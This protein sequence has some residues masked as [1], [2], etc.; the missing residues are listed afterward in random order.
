MPLSENE[1]NQVAE[2]LLANYDAATPGLIF[3]EG[4]RLELADA[5][6]LQTA[7]TKLRE[8]R[9][10]K[11]IGYK[12]GAVDP[13]NQQM[14]GLPHPVWG[15]LWESELHE[16]GA[17]LAKADYANIAIE[18][19]FGITL[20]CDLSPEMSDQEIAS[21]V[22]AV[23][24]VLELH[25][26]VMRSERP[27]GQELIANNCINCGVVRGA[28]VTDLI[29]PRETD[30]KLIYDGETVDEWE[31]LRWPGDI[32]SAMQ[33]LVQS[34]DESGLGLK[35]GDLVLTSAWGPPIPVNDASRV[36]VTSSALGRV[37]AVF[38]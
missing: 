30:L 4:F 6:R 9:G 29:D 36:D 24:P 35:A 19:E 34:L 22:N 33:W 16:D 15:R 21:S 10:E 20:S 1:L 32:L 23:F 5:W 7:V 8:A 3:G 2:R 31:T 12:V 26:L 25:N 27:H 28:P 13:G 11:V 17:A 14:M 38:S 18:A 37:S